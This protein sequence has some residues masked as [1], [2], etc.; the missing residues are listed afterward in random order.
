MELRNTPL[1]ES[2][3]KVSK[4]FYPGNNLSA[5]IQFTKK[6]FEVSISTESEQ[7]ALD[8]CGKLKSK[9]VF[10]RPHH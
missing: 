7:Q 1:A 10:L 6:N 4:L 2:R 3:L 5:E 8:L 9:L